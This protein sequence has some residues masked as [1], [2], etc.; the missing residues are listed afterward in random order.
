M[1]FLMTPVILA[2]LEIPIGLI[3]LIEIKM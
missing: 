2:A 1:K 3:D